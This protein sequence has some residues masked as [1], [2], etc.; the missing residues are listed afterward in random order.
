M[1]APAWP[2]CVAAM[3]G[4]AGLGIGW[5]L[6]RAGVLPRSFE[7]YSDYAEDESDVFA[8]YPHARREMINADADD[9][10]AAIDRESEAD[11]ALYALFCGL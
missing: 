7:D 8:D 6:L 11:E 4:L 5:S 10:D 3:G 9:M 1:A 2:V